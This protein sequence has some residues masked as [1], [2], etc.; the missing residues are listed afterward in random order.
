MTTLRA[1]NQ[2]IK[3]LQKKFSGRKLRGKKLILQG[4]AKPSGQHNGAK[5]KEK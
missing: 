5:T 4:T 1:G 2:A 3:H